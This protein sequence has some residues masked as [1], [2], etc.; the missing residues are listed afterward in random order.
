[1][2][3][4]GTLEYFQKVAEAANASEALAKT[5]MD[6]TMIYVVTDLKLP[7]GN[8][9]R[10]FLKFEKGKVVEVREANTAE[11]ADLVYTAKAEI[12]QR[13]FSGSLSA[14]NAMKTG[15][16]KM[17]YKLGKVLRYKGAMD[18]YSR[19]VPTVQADY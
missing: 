12:F 9:S 13:L 18:T 15:W 5:K 10:H 17:K 14:D 7:N 4:F 8:E 16:L 2:V 6:L 19:L 11:D 3:K 1:L